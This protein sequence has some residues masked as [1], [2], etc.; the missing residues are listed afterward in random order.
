MERY[1]VSIQGFIPVRKDPFERSEMVTQVLFGEYVNILDEGGK[2][3]YVK[4][5]RDGYEGWIDKKCIRIADPETERDAIVFRQ[6]C[7]LSNL[8]DQTGI[9]IPIGSS[10]PLSADHSFIL[11]GKTFKLL[12]PDKVKLIG[13]AKLSDLV[14]EIIGIPYLWG[15]RC[16]FGFDCSGLQQYLCRSI[17]KEL[18]R[19]ASEQAA[20]GS[21]LS[22][23]NE[24]LPGDLAFFDDTE[25]MIH[26]VG[27]V[28]EEH[29]I[30][31]A[32]GNV[33]IDHID[34]QGIYNAEIGE[35]THKLRVLKRVL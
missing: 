18:P 35:Y 6:N 32:S 27:M 25:G 19:D 31:H 8:S 10:V 2:W 29:K 20:Q 5:L 28:L 11:S 23:I 7:M 33:R 12:D 24:T 14:P 3:Q 16:G 26:H 4:L 15:G 21:T 9:V 1:G 22:F 30:L 34:Q 17:G 13:A